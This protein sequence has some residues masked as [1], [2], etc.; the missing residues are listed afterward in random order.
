MDATY[1]D[2]VYCVQCAYRPTVAYPG[3]RVVERPWN[4][5][6]TAA[7][8]GDLRTAPRPDAAE[9]AGDEGARALCPR[10]GSERL[11]RLDL[12]RP[13]DNACYRCGSCGHIFS[14]ALSKPEDQGDATLA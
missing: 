4:S 7:D 5:A 8:V 2:D 3:P 6:A 14:P 11:V 9:E 1:R 13:Q 10:C 12:L